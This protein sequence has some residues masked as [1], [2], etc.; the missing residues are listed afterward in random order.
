MSIGRLF[1]LTKNKWVWVS[2]AFLRSIKP[3][4]VNGFGAFLVREILFG[5][6]SLVQNLE[7]YK[8]IGACKGRS[9]E[10]MGTETHRREKAPEGE[11]LAGKN[12]GCHE[13]K[14]SQDQGRSKGYNKKQVTS[15]KERYT[16][17]VSAGSEEE[18]EEDEGR[19]YGASEQ[20][21]VDGKIPEKAPTDVD[22]EVAGAKDGFLCVVADSSGSVLRGASQAGGNFRCLVRNSEM[23][24]SGLRIEVE[25]EDDLRD[26]KRAG[27]GEV[28]LGSSDG[29]RPES[30]GR[31]CHF[32]REEQEE[33]DPDPGQILGAGRGSGTERASGSEL[34]RPNVSNPVMG[35][36]Y[37]AALNPVS[38]IW[39][40][41]NG[42][43]LYK[44]SCS[45]VKAAVLEPGLCQDLLSKSVAKLV[46]FGSTFLSSE[47][48]QKGNAINL[49]EGDEIG[50]IA[51]QDDGY[52]SM[53]KY[54]DN[55]Y[56]QHSPIS[57]SVFG[58]P[59]LSG[60]FSGQR[61]SVPDKTLVLFRVEAADD[62][63]WGSPGTSFDI[64]E[65]NGEVG[66][67]KTKCNFELVEN[68][69]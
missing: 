8:G 52:S 18:E 69:K 53:N 1:V 9:E 62:R 27:S 16:I 64:G 63:D 7:R 44:P 39:A 31:E 43:S 38:S 20:E 30:S 50:E 6:M 2:S 59:L 34:G 13:S 24:T 46:C 5:V 67:R 10:K 3:F 54:D 61:V 65:G 45:K 4:Y 35:L 40:L 48:G 23:S 17:K 66:Q 56:S 25:G 15:R 37:R 58:R 11:M 68:W 60:G 51:V 42:M 26:G 21:S 29:I 12:R 55:R 33:T 19:C 32:H 47:E 49:G 41:F 14:S 22:M 28:R 36:F 57:I